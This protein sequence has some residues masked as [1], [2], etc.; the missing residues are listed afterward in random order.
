MI[1][2]IYTYMFLHIYMYIH[3]HVS[4]YLHVYTYIQIR[5]DNP[6]TMITI[7]ITIIPKNLE[8]VI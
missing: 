5:K 1:K 6:G 4:T 8:K 3:I 2:C 7:M